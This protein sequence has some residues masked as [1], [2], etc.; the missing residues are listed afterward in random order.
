MIGFGAGLFERQGMLWIKALHVFFVVAWFVGLFYLPRLF[1]Y[2]CEVSDAA[3]HLRFCRMERRLLVMATLGLVGTVG[4]G[5]LLWIGLWGMPGPPWLHAK[6]A[7]VALLLA[8]HMW[9]WQQT[10]VFASGGQH[11]SARYF[12]WM[13]EV[14]TLLLLGVLLLVEIKPHGGG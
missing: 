2:H 1:V 9:M 14:P 10:R 5:L 6:L 7:L 3:G 4:C 13:N 12:R 11:R 8:F